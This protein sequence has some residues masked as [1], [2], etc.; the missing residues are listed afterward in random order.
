MPDANGNITPTDMWDMEVTN[1]GDRTTAYDDGRGNITVGVGHAMDLN[2]Q[3][4]ITN[5]PGNP[6]FDAVHDGQQSLT[7]DQVQSLFDLDIRTPDI[8]PSVRVVVA[9]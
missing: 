9:G 8:E 2:A 1:E 6:D 7:P 4:D 5:L 3:S